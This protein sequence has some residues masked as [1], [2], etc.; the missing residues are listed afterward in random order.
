MRTAEALL[1]EALRQLIALENRIQL[2]AAMKL[3]MEL[4]IEQ[5]KLIAALHLA[6]AIE[7][8]HPTVDAAQ[9]SKIPAHVM[10]KLAPIQHLIDSDTITETWQHGTNLALDSSIVH[11]LFV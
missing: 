11:S 9:M 3:L 7:S 5:G 10:E 6:G 8:I 4:A 1:E 2:A